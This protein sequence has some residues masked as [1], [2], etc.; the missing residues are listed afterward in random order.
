[1]SPARGLTVVPL[2][3]M[4]PSRVVVAWKQGDTNPVIRSFVRI[5]AAAYG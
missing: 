5:A 4:E 2:I 3:D 1:M